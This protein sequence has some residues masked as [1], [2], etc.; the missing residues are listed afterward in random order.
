[1]APAASS[2]SPD[3]V[4]WT[5]RTSPI[6]AWSFNAPWPTAACWVVVGERGSTTSTDGLA[7][8]NVSVNN[9]NTLTDVAFNGTSWVGCGS[10]GTIVT[11]P[12]GV[13]WTVGYSGN[14][15][16]LFGIACERLAG[17]QRARPAP[18]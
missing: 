6:T 13:S 2:A 10:G 1:M 7:W 8:T 12:D 14:D 15:Y 11:S 5:A 18:S 9:T 17:W 16:G 4:T 3:A